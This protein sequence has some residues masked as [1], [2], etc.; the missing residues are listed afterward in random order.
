MYTSRKFQTKYMLS[1]PSVDEFTTTNTTRA[2]FH[3]DATF[4][5]RAPPIEFVNHH[6]ANSLSPTQ[7]PWY[8]RYTAGAL[9]QTTLTTMSTMNWTKIR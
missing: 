6:S 8:T 1:A 4:R 3:V 7:Q 2:A 5:S 9:I